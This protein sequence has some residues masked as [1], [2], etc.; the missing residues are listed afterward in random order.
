MIALILSVVV[1]LM[2]ICVPVYQLYENGFDAIDSF[3]DFMFWIIW[4]MLCC[5]I[6][7]LLMKWDE[8][9]NQ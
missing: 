1:A 3:G 4:T 2:G 6:S 9:K 5:F 8:F 7:I